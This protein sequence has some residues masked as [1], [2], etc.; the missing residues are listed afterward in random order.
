[1]C[2]VTEVEFV[3]M[4]DCVF[5]GELEMGWEIEG[6]EIS[7]LGDLSVRIPP[8]TLIGAV[9]NNDSP[10]EQS[11]NAKLELASSESVDNDQ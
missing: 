9:R 2:Q 7:A 11:S 10:S 1:M 5:V 4:A 3:L 8:T 6:R